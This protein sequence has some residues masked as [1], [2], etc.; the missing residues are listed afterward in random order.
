MS[1][2]I[3]IPVNKNFHI[4]FNDD[5]SSSCPEHS[6]ITA[7]LIYPGL[8]PKN[9]GIIAPV[10]SNYNSYNTLCSM[11]GKHP[12]SVSLEYYPLDTSLGS[13]YPYTIYYDN[14]VQS[15]KKESDFNKIISKFTGSDFW[16]RVILI[17]EN[18]NHPVISYLEESL[19]KHSF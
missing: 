7:V 18:P 16:G 12:I 15:I 8:Y 2:P 6:I 5:Y 13:F 10:T 17:D 1:K 11:I 19:T 9:P 3:Q 4:N 14:S